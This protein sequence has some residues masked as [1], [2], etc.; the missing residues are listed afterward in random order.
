M[1][2]KLNKLSFH[3]EVCL[4]RCVS[5]AGCVLSALISQVTYELKFL[6]F[7]LFYLSGWGIG[8]SVAY[9]FLRK[10]NIA[11]AKK[12]AW[13]YVEEYLIIPQKKGGVEM[14]IN[15]IGTQLL[16]TTVPYFMHKMT[17]KPYQQEL[18]FYFLFAK[19]KQNL[20]RC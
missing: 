7:F 6:E 10:N 16:Y 8:C 5:F 11:D 3:A 19:V 1:Q 12:L 9:W 20:F 17:I 15:D 2:R 18:A 14:E 4:G 13:D